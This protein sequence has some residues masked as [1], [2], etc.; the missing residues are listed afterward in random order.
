MPLILPSGEH[1]GKLLQKWV[2]DTFSISEI[3]YAAGAKHSLHGNEQA[4]LVFVEKG[5]YAKTVGTD[6]LAC[7]KDAL[8]FVPAQR[9]QADVFGATETTC[10]IVDFGSG[11][12]SRV[13]NSGAAIGKELLLSGAEFT[14][15]GIQL[16]E[17]FKQR[18]S[19]SALVVESLLLQILAH[20]FRVH[21]SSLR[22]MVPSWLLTTKDILRDCFPESLTMEGIASEIGVHPVHLSR[23][24][25]R[26][27]KT[28]PGNYLRRVRVDFAAIQLTETTRPLSDIAMAAGFADQ[29]HFSR[30]F[31]RLTKLS[32]SEFRR[33]ARKR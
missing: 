17:E 32:P 26:F 25:R 15:A 20:G 33:L 7:T 4:L 29:A 6:E 24:F 28:T 23:E 21:N 31:R 16:A 19:V 9:L 14:A 27:F 3:K 10:L 5:G 11:F 13:L 18:D 2:S 1:Y 12:L 22:P 30:T 8:L